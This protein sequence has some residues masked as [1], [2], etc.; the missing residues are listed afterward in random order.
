MSQSKESENTPLC[1]EVEN[2]LGTFSEPVD[3]RNFEFVASSNDVG[4]C[5]GKSKKPRKIL[6][7]QKKR[8]RVFFVSAPTSVPSPPKLCIS[9]QISI[10]ED[11]DEMD[12]ASKLVRLEDSFSEKSRRVEIFLD[13]QNSSPKLTTAEQK[14]SLV[15]KKRTKYDDATIFSI[16]STV[17]SVKCLSKVEGTGLFDIG[18]L[19]SHLSLLAGVSFVREE[20]WVSIKHHLLLAW[21]N[22]I[23]SFVINV[24]QVLTF[25]HCQKMTLALITVRKENLA[26]I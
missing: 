16:G 5:S 8:K 10:T 2:V 1:T 20:I 4:S 6:Y 7:G 24:L 25:M 26:T 11:F 14:I 13:S 12:L 9:S 23:F 15:G 22:A 3:T 18:I 21:P 19:E 17:P